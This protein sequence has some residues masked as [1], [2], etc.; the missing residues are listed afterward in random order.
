MFYPDLENSGTKL[1]HFIVAEA[2]GDLVYRCNWGMKFSITRPGWVMKPDD[3]LAHA[4]HRFYSVS[5]LVIPP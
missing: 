3:L 5:K 1:E 2:A 4:H